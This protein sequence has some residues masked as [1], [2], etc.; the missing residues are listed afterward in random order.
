MI[1]LFAKVQKI[2]Q[3]TP[4]L[5]RIHSF[6]SAYI[7]IGAIQTR[8]SHVFSD[9]AVVVAVLHLVVVVFSS[10][11]ASLWL[12]WANHQMTLAQ[13]WAP[14]QK[15][16]FIS[17]FHLPIELPNTLTSFIARVTLSFISYFIFLVKWLVS[18]ITSQ[19][20]SEK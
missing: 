14:C 7:G 8:S 12:S 15:T 18:R 13:P 3:R 10:T 19:I 9:L 20:V 2:D 4:K 6:S 11:S 1:L 17:G 16:R 5:R